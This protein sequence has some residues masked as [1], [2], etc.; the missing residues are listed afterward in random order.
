MLQCSI[1]EEQNKMLSSGQSGVLPLVWTSFR[2][3]IW[4][5]VSVLSW[6]WSNVSMRSIIYKLQG[7]ICSYSPA[8]VINSLKYLS[9][10]IDWSTMWLVYALPTV[11]FNLV[12]DSNGTCVPYVFSTVFWKQVNTF[13]LEKQKYYLQRSTCYWIFICK[14]PVPK[15]ANG[16]SALCMKLWH[17]TELWSSSSPCLA[18]VRQKLET[19]RSKM[20]PNKKNFVHECIFR[21]RFYCCWCGYFCWG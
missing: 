8:S 13:F 3:Y 10:S 21:F 20:I 12:G 11:L 19:N 16:C 6:A 1:P 17:T 9:S 4:R 14:T 15:D 7:N 5:A 2:Q 18:A